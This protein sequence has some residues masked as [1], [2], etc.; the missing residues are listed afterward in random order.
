LPGAPNGALVAGF[1]QTPSPSSFRDFPN[2]FALINTIGIARAPNTGGYLFLGVND[3]N[4]PGG[5]YS[6][7][8]RVRIFRLSKDGEDQK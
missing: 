3:F 6:G 4:N 7:A 1:S 2:G 5:D 8:F